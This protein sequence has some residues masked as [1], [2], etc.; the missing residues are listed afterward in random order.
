MELIVGMALMAIFMSMFTAAI[1][2]MTQ[3]GN[4]V[5]AVSISAARRT[6]QAFLTMDKTVRYASAITTPGSRASPGTGM[7]NSTRPTPA[8]IPARG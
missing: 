4:K 6:N 3:T 8:P 1:V 5:E 7:S 2:L